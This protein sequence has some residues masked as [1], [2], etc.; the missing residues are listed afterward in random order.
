MS[1]G[2]LTLQILH[3]AGSS[4]EFEQVLVAE[5][6]ALQYWPSERPLMR[7]SHPRAAAQVR[8]ARTNPPPGAERGT[9]GHVAP[10]GVKNAKGRPTGRPGPPPNLGGSAP[11][12]FE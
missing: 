8:C 9:R 4:R 10:Q 2:Q 1:L 5:N 6:F 7:R 12:G 11:P 3:L